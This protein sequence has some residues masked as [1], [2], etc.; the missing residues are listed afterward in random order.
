MKIVDMHCDTIMRM[1]LSDG[2]IALRENDGHIDI[3]KLQK[4]GCLAQFFAIFIPMMKMKEIYGEDSSYKYF[5]KAYEV[6][7][8]EM[9]K[10]KDFILPARNYDEIMKNKAEG[11]MSSILTI[12][13]GDPVQG[14]MERIKEFYD[15][16]VRLITLTWNFENCFGYPNSDDDTIMKKGL[17]EFGIEALSYMNEL[18]ILIDVSH[19]NEGG[20]YDVAKY[21]KKPFVASHSC[22]RNLASHKRNLWDEQ[23]KLVGETGS[24][25]GVNF[26]S[27]FLRDGSNFST[28]DDV[29]KHMLHIKDKAGM[30]AVAWGSD[31]DGIAPTLEWV[32]Y[33]G[34][35]KLEE[36]LSKHFTPREIDMINHENA[37]RV[38]KASMK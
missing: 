14:K 26:S 12:E 15:K 21:S 7:L 29:V 36:A 22:A 8:S 19:L 30:E 33:A 34:M 13:E 23:L 1:A 31:F 5:N 6:Y 11:K 2:K 20:F 37:L 16:G 32:D 25:V 18:G 24:V 27:S 28:I 9:E 17:K 10:N 3:A 38:I 35:P 4:G